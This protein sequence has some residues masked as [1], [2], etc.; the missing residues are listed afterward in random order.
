[1]SLFHYFPAQDDEDYYFA[2][3]IWQ[4]I[5]MYRAIIDDASPK[6]AWLYEGATKIYPE[7]R[8]IENMR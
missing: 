6:L 4:G 8:A 2:L 5:F 1:M 7:Y 3:W